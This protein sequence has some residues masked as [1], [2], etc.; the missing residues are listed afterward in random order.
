[1]TDAKPV[2]VT[3]QSRWGLPI[4]YAS[5]SEE[6]A[7]ALLARRVDLSFRPTPWPRRSRIEDHV[8]D[9]IASRPPYD[10][11]PQ[12]SYEQADLFF[13]GHPGY[14]IGFTMLEVDGIPRRWADSCN[15]MDEVWTPSRW[16]AERFQASGVTKPIRVVPLGYDASRFAPASGARR[17]SP[18]FTFLSVFEW[19]E[20]KAPEILLRAYA[21]AFAGPEKNDVLLVVRANNH[22]GHVNVPQQMEDLG[23]PRNGPPVAFLYNTHIRASQLATLYQGADAFVLPSRGEGWGMPILEAMACGLPV[24]A[25]PWS[26]P[27][28]FLHDGV[29]LSRRRQGASFPADAKCPYYEGFR[30]A[31]PDLDDLVAKTAP[32][33][34]APRGGLRE[35]RRR[36]AGGRRPLDVGAHGGPRRGA[37]ARDRRLTRLLVGLLYFRREPSSVPDDEWVSARVEKAR[38]ERE[39]ALAAVRRLEDEVAEPLLP[40]RRARGRPR[41]AEE[42]DGGGR[43]VRR[44]RQGVGAVAGDPVAARSRGPE[45]VSDAEELDRLR[46]EAAELRSLVRELSAQQAAAIAVLP[47]E[48]ALA[49]ARGRRGG[50]RPAVPPRALGR[51]DRDDARGRRVRDGAP[52]ADGSRRRENA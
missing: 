1:M 50:P 7:R 14:R 8:L 36:R 41:R 49:L 6:L 20:R 2:R 48:T 34:H 19:G 35:G 27:S 13:H 24:I 31:D 52:L 46:K 44:G 29:G 10:D 15:R 4:G 28:E 18:R 30:W 45:V 43:S 5:T 38:H 11:A 12:V 40:R 9:A 17:A 47:L 37:S 23:L 16:G 3:W 51:D 39:M 32:R 22:D 21:A 33:V 42:P 25:T 26:G